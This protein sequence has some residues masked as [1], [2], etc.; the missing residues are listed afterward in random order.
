[1]KKIISIVLAMIVCLLSFASCSGPSKVKVNGVKIDNEVYTYF[2]DLYEGNEEKVKKAISRYVTVNSEFN[3]RNLTL[4]ASQKSDLA[5]EVDD[6]WHIYGAHF[7]DIGVSKQTVYKIE[8]SDAYEDALLDYYYGPEGYEPVSEET[9]KKYFKE[10][11]IAISYATE[12]LFNFDETGALVPMTNE[13]KTV[14][15]DEFTRSVGL[16]NTGSEIEEATD[17][18]VQEAIIHSANDGNFPSGF[19]KEVSN[20]KVGSAGMVTLNDYVFLVK[21]NDVFDET[22]KYY[23]DYKTTCLRTLKGKSFEKLIAHWSQNY[24]AE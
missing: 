4:S 18:D 24:I 15:T 19:Y 2:D 1:M 21:R 8:L 23:D 9:L 20:I 17:K 3:N 14:I 16:I 6:L 12:Y 11:Y 7:K 10:N 5:Q 22:Y 13:E